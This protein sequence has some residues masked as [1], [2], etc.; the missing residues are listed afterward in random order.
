MHKSIALYN[1]VHE[2]G[3]K[4][5][6]CPPW[7]R[8]C[9]FLWARTVAMEDNIK[10]EEKHISEVLK[11]NGFPEYIIKSAQKPRGAKVEEKTLKYA[12]CL[13]YVSG[14]SEDVRRVCRKFDIRTVFTTISTLMIR[15]QLT[16]VK[17]VDPPLSKASVVYKVPCSCG[18]EYIGET[19]RALGTLIKE[20]QFAT[21][22][23][24]TEKSAIAEHTWAEKHH[25]AW[26][27][28]ST[29]KQAKNVDVLRIKKAFCIMLAEKQNL[30][31]RDWGTA[32]CHCWKSLLQQWK[33]HH[34]N[35][36]TIVN[37]K[38][39]CH[40]HHQPRI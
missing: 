31:N 9:L 32:V 10:K 2:G 11:T 29:I 18:K 4:C 35:P 23:G 27:K 20:H 38:S 39:S 7:I 3:C 13:S 5:P 37:S 25:P 22:G 15:Q 16:R 12:I 8:Y 21:R 34:V 6:L 26:E 19:K 17:D 40:E 1:K 33:H 28:T 14:L 36:C 24:E 30:L